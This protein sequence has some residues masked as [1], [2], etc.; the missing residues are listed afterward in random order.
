MHEIHY[1]RVRVVFRR[2][3]FPIL[4]FKSLVT[5]RDSLLEQYTLKVIS[6]NAELF[7]MRQEVIVLLRGYLR[8][9]QY[10][11]LQEVIGIDLERP[12]LVD[13]FRLFFLFI[14]RV[15]KFVLLD[16]LVVPGGRTCATTSRNIVIV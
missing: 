15:V 10:R 8:V 6:A 12:V 3:R 7:E 13:N 4:E 9:L 1:L 14:N 16:L 2:T 11:A 5:C